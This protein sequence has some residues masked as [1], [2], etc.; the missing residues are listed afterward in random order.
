MYHQYHQCFELLRVI[1]CLSLWQQAAQLTPD[2]NSYSESCR[3]KT[4]QT[5]SLRL[6]I[7]FI[8][9]SPRERTQDYFTSAKILKL[10]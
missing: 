9:D 10:P 8:Y 2:H 3:H 5:A 6:S 1:R 7:L 4:L